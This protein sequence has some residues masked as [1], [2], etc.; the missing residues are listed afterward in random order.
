MNSVSWFLYL[1]DILSGIQFFSGSIGAL[2][3]ILGVITTIAS[4][5][6]DKEDKSYYKPNE[7]FKT[8]ESVIV[9]PLK[10][11][12]PYGILGVVLGFVLM[13]V[14]I[15]IPSKETRFAIAAS[16]VGEQIIQLEE[17]QEVGGEV[18]G[19]AKDAINLLRQNIQDQL[20]EKPVEASKAD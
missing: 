5:A 10:F 17:V 1:A 9:F 20:T 15:A 16:Q 3:V 7:N 11:L 19:L 14:A 13:L 4:L 18:G 8:W 12:R 2:A 6:H